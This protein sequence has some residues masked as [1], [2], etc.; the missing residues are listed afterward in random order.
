MASI[1]R[2]FVMVAALAAAGHA[3][4]QTGYPEQGV[5]I[6]VGFPPGV[7]PDVTARLLADKFGEAW[8]KPVV[9]EN[10]AG[11]GSNI[12][13]DRV[14]K[15][16]PDGYTLLMGGNSA[17]VMSPSLYDRLPYDPVKDF[18]PIS[19]VFVAANLLAVHPDVPAKSIPELVALAK[20]Q[21]GKLTYGHAGVGT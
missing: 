11:A 12:A 7:A 2:A 14:A 10:V 9:V 16:A 4:A 18:A 3:L 19:Q 15:A 8:G 17:L 1:L 21:P 20:A 13:T 5:R 6:I